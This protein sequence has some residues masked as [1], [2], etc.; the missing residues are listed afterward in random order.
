MPPRAPRGDKTNLRARRALL[1]LLLVLAALWSAGC[2]QAASG[3]EAAPS[4]APG[5]ADSATPVPTATPV[6]VIPE[7]IVLSVETPVPVTT[8][9]EPTAIPR[10][11]ATPQPTAAPEATAT[12]EPTPTATPEPTA[13]PLPIGSPF[14]AEQ[15]LDGLSRRGV[16]YEISELRS[17][18]L[19]EA[20]G[21][22]RYASEDGPEFTLW[23][24]PGGDALK[25]DWVLP[26]SGA[27]SP[28][29]AGCSVDGGWVYWHENL[30]VA[31]EPQQPWIAEAS[32][33]Q[34]IVNVFLSLSR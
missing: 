29:I 21:A 23:V 34:T 11:L 13:V 25:A 9:P 24:Y 26:S 17:E 33:R 3:E 4:S 19:G 12:P 14:S 22:H 6:Y 32:L 7:V 28:R 27:A 31:F 20:S 18:C 5:L 15:L 10:P 1:L 30:I 16:V 8:T 2:Y